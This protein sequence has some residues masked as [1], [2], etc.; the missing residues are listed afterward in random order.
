MPPSELKG[1]RFT[2]LRQR[3]HALRVSLQQHIDDPSN[4]DQ[5]TNR[6]GDCETVLGPAPSIWRRLSTFAR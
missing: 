6:A 5:T 4:S 2:S 1:E 3:A